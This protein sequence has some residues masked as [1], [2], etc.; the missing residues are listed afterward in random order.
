MARP[1]TLFTGQWADLPLADLA[2][3]CAGWGFDGLELAC[4]GD[5]FEVD[6]AIADSGYARSAARAAREPR[7]RCLGDRRPPGRPGRLRRDR[8]APPRDPAAG[9][10]RRRRAGRCSRARRGAHEGHRTR[11]GAAR[12][13]AGQRLHRIVDLASHLLLPAERLRHDRA[14]VRG[15]RRALG[16]DPRRVRRGRAC[17]SGWRFIPPRSPTTS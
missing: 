1:C 17:A 11:R 4:W 2:A 3:R 15:L 5:H 14:R 9:D 12:R 8:H 10:L 6:R 13:D 16:P 7:A